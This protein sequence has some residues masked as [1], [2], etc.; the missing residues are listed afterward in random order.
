MDLEIVLIGQI[1]AR[2]VYGLGID[3]HVA[4]SVKHAH[5]AQIFAGRGSVE[6]G[7]LPSSWPHAG[8]IRVDDRVA[9]PLQRQIVELDI[10]T[11]II[12][13]NL[14]DAAAISFGFGPGVLA[15][16]PER[17]TTARMAQ[18]RA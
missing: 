17:A 4:G 16:F 10:P 15:R 13:Q 14:R 8:D 1:F 5:R 12:A 18:A 2:Q 7:P 11:N 3:Q 6:Q 9:E